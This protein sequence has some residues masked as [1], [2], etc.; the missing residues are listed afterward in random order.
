[1]K[2]IPKPEP[3][4]YDPYAIMYVKLLPDD[5]DILRHLRENG[6]MVKRYFSALTPDQW[7]HRYAP[8]KW[9]VKEVLLHIIDDERIYAYRALRIARNDK[10]ELPGFDQDP[11]VVASEA[12]NRTP[13]SLLNEYETVRR[14]TLSLF[15]NLPDDAWLRSGTANNHSVTVRS[16][17]YH[18]AGH[19]LHHLNILKEKYFPL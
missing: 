16:L 19:E 3:G 2:I 6:E 14:A 15:D 5:G 13:E 12:N 8:E 7:L 10:T 4:E 11:Y 9:S 18:L 17:V 1:M